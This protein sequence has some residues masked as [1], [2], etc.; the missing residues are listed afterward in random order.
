M[1]EG[2][3][4]DERDRVRRPEADDIVGVD[5]EHCIVDLLDLL[6]GLFS[7]EAVQEEINI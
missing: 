4:R 1:A 7:R 3:L 6:D 5:L 2:I